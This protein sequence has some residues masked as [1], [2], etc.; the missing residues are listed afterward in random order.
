MRKAKKKEEKQKN[1]NIIE[2]KDEVQIGDYV[3]E[4]GDRILIEGKIENLNLYNELADVLRDQIRNGSDSFKD[5]Q[6]FARYL[7]HIRESFKETKDMLYQS[8]FGRGDI[9]T[10]FRKFIIG[11]VSEVE[12]DDPQIGTFL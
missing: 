1:K 4:K 6:T 5:G 9:H 12:K 8:D 3:L 7:L 2:I 10:Y 11:F